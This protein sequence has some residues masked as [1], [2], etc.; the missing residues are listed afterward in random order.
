MIALLFA[1]AIASP[2]KSAQNAV[3]ETFKE[4][5]SGGTITRKIQFKIVG[6]PTMR[7]LN[8]K[9]DF[10]KSKCDIIW[11]CYVTQSNEVCLPKKIE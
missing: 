9:T 5:F 3:Y 6:L 8:F 11:I 7:R 4:N 10:S 2:L 1:A